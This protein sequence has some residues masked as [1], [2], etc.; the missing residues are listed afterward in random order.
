MNLKN[1]TDFFSGLLFM[2][3]GVAF[4]WGASKYPIG[5]AAQM[6]PGY[7]PLLLGALLGLLGAVIVFK[8]LVFETEDGGRI[9]PWAWRPLG[10]ILLV[11]LLFGVLLGGPPPSGQ[12]LATYAL[13]SAM[14][15]L[16]LQLGPTETVA[17]MVLGLLVAA[18]LVPGAL[19][20][21][22]AMLLLGLLL[23]LVG[24]GS[25]FGVVRFA[26]NVPELSQGIGLVALAL[27]VFGYAE[28]ITNVTRFAQLREVPGDRA[29]GL[30]GKVLG[31]LLSLA[32]RWTRLPRLPYR[33]LLPVIV[34][35]CALAAYAQHHS[36][37][38]VWL[39]AAFGCAGYLFKQLGMEPVPLL[40]G[41]VL[42]P[43]MEQNLRSALLL[44]GGDWSVFVARP[45]SAGLLA[46]ALFLMLL[47]P[48]MRTRR[49]QA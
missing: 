35:L 33:W 37:F 7:F 22:L 36:S 44:S 39:L 17:L 40:L 14:S 49:A 25:D 29:Q 43:M 38:D 30:R 16:V 45:L 34:L 31:S 21:A 3:L 26:W 8:A 11:N 10:F 28:V 48:F 2:A 27:G 1:Q 6:G 5:T 9:G 23:G 19:L 12:L 13:P 32:R 42:A 20:K 47:L 18:V 41:Y 46:T 15:R 24:A 4:A